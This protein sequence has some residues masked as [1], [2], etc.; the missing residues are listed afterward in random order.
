M[1]ASD[2]VEHPYGA[3]AEAVMK[4]KRSLGQVQED[5]NVPGGELFLV[6]QTRSDTTN[7]TKKRSLT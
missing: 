2:Q 4:H 6:E 3:D 1:I 5:S 7:E